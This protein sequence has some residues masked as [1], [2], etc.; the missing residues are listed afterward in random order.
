MKTIE[1]IRN[2]FAKEQKFKNWT[3]YFLFML[4][5][6]TLPERMTVVID[7]IAE[8]YAAQFKQAGNNENPDNFPSNEVILTEEIDRLKR[9]NE[10]LKEQVAN[11]KEDI[12]LP[13]ELE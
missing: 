3:E 7:L 1:Q 8:S 6:K 2:E 13:Y 9:E 10:N 11:L 4:R 5:I 12:K